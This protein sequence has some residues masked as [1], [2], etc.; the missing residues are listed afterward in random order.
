MWG[1]VTVSAAATQRSFAGAGVTKGA[2]R[3]PF[4]GWHQPQS[5][6]LLRSENTFVAPVGARN[7][8]N[9]KELRTRIRAIKSIKK[10][11]SS[12]KL[13][14]ASKL[15]KAQGRMEKSRPFGKA[16]TIFIDREYPPLP[17]DEEEK[18]VELNE[19]QINQL[20]SA[21]GTHLIV[22]VTSDRGLCGGVNSSI[23][24]AAKKLAS[25]NP[26][27]VA[28]A[29]IGDKSVAGLNK[30]YSQNYAIS[31]SKVSGNTKTSYTEVAQIADQ[32]MQIPCDRMTII[33]NTFLNVLTFSTRRRLLPSRS[34]FGDKKRYQGVEFEEGREEVL[35][36]LYAFNLANFLWKSIV[37]AHV[38]ELGAR[39]TSMDNATKNAT[40]VIDRLSLKYNKQRQEKITTE[41]NEIVSGATAIDVKDDD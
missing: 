16:A 39:M 17:L 19:A 1:R 20:S 12:M 40:A 21:P 27:N 26:Q 5:T 22:T 10:I 29:L 13:V 25:Y 35:N 33:A 6:S 15:T 7:A 36:D 2:F 3:T 11:T 31:I 28:F 24:K 14:A 8:G 9:M 4:T 30:E 41:L 23:V 38:V 34:A 32:I 18:E 37:E